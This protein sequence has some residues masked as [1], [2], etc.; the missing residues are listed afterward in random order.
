MARGS[1]PSD[2]G[3][4]PGYRRLCVVD[5][6]V[7]VSGLIDG[8]SARPPAR[9]LD[10]M[11]GGRLL[12]M[13]SPALL[14][15]YSAVLRRPAIA[16]RHGLTLDE[17][18]RFLTDLVADAVW[19]EP[20]EA[21]DAPDIGDS[22]LWNLLA[23]ERRAQLITGDRLLLRTPPTGA[24]VVSPRQFVEAFLFLGSR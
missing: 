14:G 16:E 12:Y 23:S 6:N 24:S 13:M 5:T 8:D 11:I 10:A 20:D 2:T 18:D 7:V 19:R 9:I 21:G 1:R 3:R 17:L 15:E 4:G 22:H